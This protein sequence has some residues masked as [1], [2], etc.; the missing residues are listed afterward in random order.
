[1]IRIITLV[2]CL[3]FASMSF[4]T[5]ENGNYVGLGLG[6]NSCDKFISA[7]DQA[8]KTQNLIAINR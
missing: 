4:G 1:M 7:F 5:D 2:L 8:N 3:S 6:T